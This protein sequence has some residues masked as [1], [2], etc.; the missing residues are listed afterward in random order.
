KSA[1]YSTILEQGTGGKDIYKIVFLGAE[2]EIIF[3]QPS[4]MVRGFVPPHENAFSVLPDKF[5]VDTSLLVRGSI[6]NSENQQPVFAKMDII[7]AELSRV[8][9][10]T[11]SDSS[12]SY[13][14]RIPQPKQYGIEIVARNYMLYLDLLDLSK[15]S[16]HNEIIRNFSLEPI[17]VG[18]KMILKNIFFEFGK[19]TLKQESF[20]QL[21]NVVLL[22]KSTP[23]LRIEISGHTD[24]V[25]S[26]KANQRLSEERAKAVVNYIVSRGIDLVRLEY[27]GYGFAQPVASNSTPEGRAQNRRVEFKIIGK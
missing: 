2:K 16:Y 26:A 5:V 7:D 24:N 11:T 3:P 6:T 18:A 19:S 21:D 14:I 17:E 13:F 15:E 23:G 4:M 9:A 8:I 25:G 12:G 20:I 1:Y 27:K 22:M 10:T